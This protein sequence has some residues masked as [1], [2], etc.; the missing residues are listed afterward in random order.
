MSIPLRVAQQNVA[1]YFGL[2]NSNQLAWQVVR[3]EGILA[4][5]TSSISITRIAAVTQRP[6]QVVQGLRLPALCYFPSS[7][8][9]IRDTV[10]S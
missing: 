8:I 7:T 6:E 9:I 3:P 10:I 5:N 4:S 2:P 1:L